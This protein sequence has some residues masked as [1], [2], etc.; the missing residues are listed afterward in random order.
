ML[1]KFEKDKDKQ[2]R[3]KTLQYCVK[4]SKFDSEIEKFFMG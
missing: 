3:K 4:N 2:S 1:H